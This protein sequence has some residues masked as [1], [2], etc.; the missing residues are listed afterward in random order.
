MSFNNLKLK[1]LLISFA[2]VIT[3]ATFYYT[4]NL[5]KELQKSE[6]EIVELYAK[7]LEFIANSNPTGN[8]DFTFIFENIIKRINFPLILTDAN[9]NASIYQLGSS[10]K[11]IEIDS[12]LNQEQLQIFLNRKVKELSNIHQP[13]TVAYKDSANN[14]IILNKI[15]YGNSDVVQKL[16]YYPFLQ[17]LFAV[18]FLT[19]S[20]LSFSYL[21]KNE[22]SN[23][24]VGMAK[25]IAHQLGTP[26]SSLMGW[27]ELLKLKYKKPE[28]V[29]Y[30]SNEMESD[31]TR[32]NKI[33]NRFSK[34]GSKPIL[35]E[36][37][38]AE[39]IYNVTKYFERRLPQTGK[40][41]LLIFNSTKKIVT[42]LNS[43]LFEWVIENLIK[44]AIDAIGSK[45]GKIEISLSENDDNIIIEVADNGKGIS[46][47]HKKDIFKPGYSTKNRGWG[48]GLSLSKRIIE[49]YHKGKLVLKSSVQDEGTVFRI[50]LPKEIS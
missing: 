32:L 15:Y 4:Q 12:T 43:E 23:I 3:F 17:I 5:V 24:W 26:I 14:T 39:S 20:Y 21:K 44:N 45:K 11:N 50:I 49:D 48:L 27:T 33:T 36:K 8:E 29:L 42:R 7:S 19:I 13:I 37:N 9:D 40:D 25:E 18:L 41:V 2:V 46:S 22:Q 1:Y 28:E 30:V 6:R 34:I 10:V 47:K 35:K 31:L 16:Q 38:I